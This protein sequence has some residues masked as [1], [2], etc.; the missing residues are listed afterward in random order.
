[1]KD[2]KTHWNKVYTRNKIEE[3]GWY[4]KSPEPS[5]QLINKCNLNKNAS[6]LNVGAG[7]STLVDELLSIGYNKI[8][9]SDLS[10]VA[11]KKL[12]DRIGEKE[13]SKVHWLVDDLTFPVELNKL[14]QI[15]L[16]HDRAVLHF[17]TEE[18]DSL[19]YFSLLKK[20]VKQNGFVIIAAFNLSGSPKCSGLPVHRYDE[21]MLQ[22]KLGS[23]FELMESFNYNYTMPSG[24]L[25]YYVYTLFR[26]FKDINS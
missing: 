11:L 10:S 2:V 19:S 6:I 8:I 3:L 16:W 17:F 5:I 12:K 9:A 13:S 21:N 26:R 20:I 18:K 23:G 7:A 25:R 1:M 4:E 14:E 22:E 15:D 24:D